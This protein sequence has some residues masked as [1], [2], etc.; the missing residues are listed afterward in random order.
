MSFNSLCEIP[1][2]VQAERL[3]SGGLSILFVRF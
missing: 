1:G 2:G 3:G